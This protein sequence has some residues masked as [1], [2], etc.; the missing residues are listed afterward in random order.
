[1][2]SRVRKQVS[3]LRLLSKAKPKTACAIIKA[4]DKQLMDALCECA[5]N[6]LKGVVPL[7]SRQRGRLQK[8]KHHLRALAKKT[9]SSQKKKALL[10]KGGFLGA[11]L[12]PILGVLGS[13]LR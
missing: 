2:S 4:G 3:L 7:S 8:Y 1:M 11:L 12:N 10:Q 5:L 13:L 6:I 9:L